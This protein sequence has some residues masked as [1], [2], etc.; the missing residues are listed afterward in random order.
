METYPLPSSPS[1]KVEYLRA[2]AKWKGN[3]RKKPIFN[4]SPMRRISLYLV[5]TI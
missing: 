2:T 5:E 1:P 4:F 3:L